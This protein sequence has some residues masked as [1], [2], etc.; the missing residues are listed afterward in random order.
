MNFVQSVAISLTAVTFLAVQPSQAS[1][2]DDSATATAVGHRSRCNTR[3]IVLGA[4]V[5]AAAV[6]VGVGIWAL[7]QHLSEDPSPEMPE[8]CTAFFH[9]VP[10][11]FEKLLHLGYSGQTL[12][13]AVKY[14]GW[15]VKKPMGKDQLCASYV[16]EGPLPNPEGYGYLNPVMQQAW[17]C[18]PIKDWNIFGCESQQPSIIYEG[19]RALAGLAQNVTDHMG[20]MAETGKGILRFLRG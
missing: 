19:R 4:A 20:D 2:H 10:A 12:D 8:E 9:G 11:T 15:F 17:D 6:G 5:T 16:G 3:G 18:L 1:I 13:E 14:F 7:V